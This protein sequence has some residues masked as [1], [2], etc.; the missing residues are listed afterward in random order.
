MSAIVTTAPVVPAAAENGVTMSPTF[1]LLVSTMPVKGARISVW[2]NA[3][4]ATRKFASATCDLRTQRFDRGL[5]L[6]EARDSGIHRGRRDEVLLQQ[7]ARAPERLFGVGQFRLALPQVRL[8]GG[9]AGGGLF[10]R[11]RHVAVLDARDDFAFLD[12]LPFLHTQPL[13][14]PGRFARHR[15]AARGR[16]TAGGV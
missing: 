11:G 8:G 3:T 15:C 4:V 9:N 1:A 5:R 16:N 13:E 6:V 12:L 14:A 7:L 2:S 10:A